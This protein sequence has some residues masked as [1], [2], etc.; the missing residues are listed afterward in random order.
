[1]ILTITIR[2]AVILV[3]YGSRRRVCETWAD[4]W[5]VWPDETY[6]PITQIKVTT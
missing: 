1:M 2:P 4:V 5:R 6:Q 3:T